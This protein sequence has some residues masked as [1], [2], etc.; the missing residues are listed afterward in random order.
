MSGGFT[1][2]SGAAGGGGAPSYS[3]GSATYSA[4]YTAIYAFKVAWLANGGTCIKSYDGTTFSEGDILTS[5]ATLNHAGVFFV[6]VASTG[7]GFLFRRLATDRAWEIRASA[8]DV[9]FTGGSAGVPPTSADAGV[10]R[11]S[12]SGP[13]P[14][15]GDFVMSHGVETDGRSR[16]WIRTQPSYFGTDGGTYSVG[17]P[18]YPNIQWTEGDNYT[19][20]FA[21]DA[22]SAND[23]W[24]A[25]MRA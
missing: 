24:V 21:A 19:Q 25:T 9:G 17:T 12:D 4:G 15:A 11:L 8:V 5:A 13:F 22:E 6:L 14:A 20:G 16:W 3:E 1:S 18:A 10:G 23:A 7:Q 2:T